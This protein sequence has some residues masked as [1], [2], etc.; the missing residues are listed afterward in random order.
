MYTSFVD[1]VWQL[2]GVTKWLADL[3]NTT[4]TSAP[5]FLNN[6]MSSN[7]LYA[8]IEPVIPRAIFNPDTLSYQRSVF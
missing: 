8:A 2:S 5:L 3:V 7:D 4:L 1:N 6:L